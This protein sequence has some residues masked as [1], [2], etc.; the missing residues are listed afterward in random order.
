MI[1]LSKLSTSTLPRRIIEWF[2]WIAE[3]GKDLDTNVLRC[4]GV[5][6]DEISALL[7]VVLFIS[8]SLSLF[9]TSPCV[10]VVNVLVPTVIIK[11]LE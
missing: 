9:G 1:S 4:G 3:S 8:L 11:N 10:C 5:R 6:D 2:V 7:A